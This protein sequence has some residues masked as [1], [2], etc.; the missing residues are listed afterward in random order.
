MYGLEFVGDED[1]FAALEAGIAAATGIERVAP[2]LAIADAVDLPQI[3][4]NVPSR[5]G[6][7]IPVDVTEIGVPS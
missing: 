2:G 5:T 7:S 1:R 6:R 4:Y 3:V